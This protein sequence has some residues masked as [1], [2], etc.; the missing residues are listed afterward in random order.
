MLREEP[1][2]CTVRGTTRATEDMS[3]RPH[4]LRSISKLWTPSPCRATWRLRWMCSW[5]LCRSRSSRWWCNKG[6]SRWW[7]FTNRRG[8]WWGPTIRTRVS[9]KPSTT[10]LATRLTTRRVGC[11]HTGIIIIHWFRSCS[12]IYLMVTYFCILLCGV[13]FGD[14]LRCVVG[15]HK[16]H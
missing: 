7:W 4:K 14:G 9:I 5:R 11:R 12:L 2:S 1:F 10:R 3:R 16:W 13:W 8:W 6:S 15:W